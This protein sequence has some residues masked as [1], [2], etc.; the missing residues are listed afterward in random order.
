MGAFSGSEN[1][2]NNWEYKIDKVHHDEINFLSHFNSSKEKC[3]L[4][5]EKIGK[6]WKNFTINSEK[7]QG[8]NNDDSDFG[9]DRI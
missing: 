6:S 2:S 7:V 9:D 5:G 1:I 4:K 8:K 3:L